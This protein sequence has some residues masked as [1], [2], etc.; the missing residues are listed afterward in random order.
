M[1][2]TRLI[3]SIMTCLMSI[4]AICQTDMT[5][6][7]VNPNFDGQSFAG[8]QQQGMQLQTNNDFAY[9][10]NYA[11]AEKWV[12]NTGNLP[13]TYIRQTIKGLTKG[14]YRLT[15]GAHH[16]KQGSSSAT[17]GGAIFAD[18]TETA[19]SA[20]KDYTVTFDVLTDEVTIGFKTTNSTANWMACD[21]FRLS[22]ISTDVSYMRTGLTNLI[23]VARS[24]VSQSM[25]SNVKS[26]LESAI[27]HA[28]S[29]TSNGTAS[30]IQAAASTLKTSMLNAER[31]IFATN[32]ST[33]GTVPT[34][35]TD[36][37]YA[38]GA[39]MI[40]GRSTVT[41][42]ASVKEKGFC[43]STTNPV[44]TVADERT[45][46]YIENGGPI[47]CLDNLHPATLYYIRA[48]ATTTTGKVG[49][50]DV[51]K[52]YTLPLGNITYSY[53]NAGSD[54]QNAR[55]GQSV[56]GG[57]YYWQQLT[58]IS[59]FNL[60]AHYVEG[61]GASGGTADCSYGG[62]M[63]V[64]QTEAYQSTGTILHEA[65]HGIGV[66]TTS[67]YTGDIRSNGSSGIWYGKRATRFLQFWDNSNGVRLTGD[68]TH[69][70][71]TGA[72]QDLSYTINGAHEDKHTDASYYANSLLMQAVVED[73]L[74][75]VNG[76]LQGLAYTFEHEEGKTYYIRNSDENC[77]L[78]ASY[79]IDNNGSLEQ[80]TLS[81]DEAQV[82]TNNAQWLLS[83]DPA[84]QTYRLRNK[85]TGRYIYY[86]KDNSVNGFK[87]TADTSNEVDL[88]LQLSFVDVS[89]GSGAASMTFDCYHIM[90]RNATPSPQALSAND[91]KATAS[92]TFSNSRAATTQ[93]WLILDENEISEINSALQEEERNSL[94]ELIAQIRNLAT[95][96]H[97]EKTANADTSLENSLQGIEAREAAA[98][99]AT[100]IQ[101]T[102]EAKRALMTFMRNTTPTDNPYDI[103]FLIQNAGL[104]S[105]NGYS[106]TKPSLGYSCAEFYE[107]TFDFYQTI[108]GAPSGRYVFK[109][110]GYQRP[111]T[112]ADTYADYV[113]GTTT[114]PITSQVY[115]GNDYSLV[116][117]IG[118]DAQNQKVG[119]G[120]EAEVGSPS[121]FI[122]NDMQAAAA[123]F[124]KGL[125]DN[126][127]ETTLN[128][129][130]QTLRFG[131]RGSSVV[132]ADWT[133]FDNFRLYY[134]GGSVES[135]DPATEIE[136]YD[137][138]TAYAPYL[139]TGSLKAWTNNGMYTNYNNGKDNK[140]NAADGALINFPFIERWTSNANG[141][142]LPD[143]SIQ[144]TITELPN[145]TYYIRGSFIAVNQSTPTTDVTGVTFFA[146]NQQK[147]VAT[148]DGI[149][150]RYS[151]RVEVTDGT[152]TY[153]LRT[154][155]TTANWIA[156]DNFSL[157][158]AGT[159]EEYFANATAEVP[160]RVPI[161][162]P[163]FDNKDTNGWTLNGAWELLNTEYDNFNAPFLEKWTSS[164]NTLP[165]KSITQTKLLRKG[166][167]TLRA[168]VEAVR[169]GQSIEVSGV[170]MRFDD[171]E[172]NCHTADGKPQVYS[173]TKEV[174][175][176]SHTFGIYVANTN[177]NWVAVDNF[178][179]YYYAPD[180]FL[181]G[182]VN[183]DGL[184]DIV[185]VTTLTNHL[186]GKFN[187][188]F[189][190][191]AADVNGDNSIDIADV[192]RLASIILG[193][194]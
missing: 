144:Q 173:L 103:T 146:G 59:G 149:P 153:G 163:A 29:L 112:S 104:D 141:G 40:F 160:V 58:S 31:S 193:K 46:R 180:D 126:T 78:K 2:K 15:V 110:Q 10:S 142:R 189:I 90:R 6:S 50:G 76:N 122:P 109:L 8:W 14:R 52:V 98:D 45:S 62:W 5:S 63:R 3:F 86:A 107:K 88:R 174:E 132:T 47:Y 80:K 192:T 116:C 185:D 172:V 28:S 134:Y 91:S 38:R 129:N 49:Y 111:G 87:T 54:I 77:G 72:A 27:N 33:S 48:Y 137:V 1:N 39:T 178:Q 93:R 44:P 36:T 105:S 17:N 19:V 148:D 69:L 13:D 155:S 60:S 32:V 106:G 21:N 176:G 117:H 26:A 113:A 162:N 145:G 140:T 121:R 96:S 170:T 68:G 125:Y 190:E 97:Q 84:T 154:R 43:Y 124:A 34:V 30:Q 64:S 66:G 67:S 95:T 177:A 175:E 20:A 89:L 65:G 151:L 12:S 128:S 23:T 143:T 181:L 123:Y 118:K 194:D 9:K 191:K 37:R 85:N 79:L 92:T 139:G 138:T 18:W 165:D 166:K 136:G 102:E 16:I 94:D 42:S 11:Y 179:L 75:P 53:D 22:L 73:G 131:I 56:S 169:Q 51:L 156:M 61:A 135:Q 57:M 74:C 130:N 70:W 41:S 83:F 108:T 35:I 157:I 7:I 184:V 24:L 147:S 120:K 119:T 82:T 127:V 99:V 188:V 158:Y 101:L 71:A 81:T 164:T 150:E 55:I 187:K 161:E 167:Y 115:I 114:H 100:L 182:D 171:M 183:G 159:E 186:L 152:L 168:A 4:T 25:D 133:I